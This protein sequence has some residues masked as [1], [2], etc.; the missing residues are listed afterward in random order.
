[1]YQHPYL[2]I[3]YT[4]FLNLNFI[5]I[6]K[7]LR[8]AL[9]CAFYM[10]CFMNV[11]HTQFHDP[12]EGTPISPG[13]ITPRPSNSD[14]SIELTVEHAYALPADP[15]FVVVTYDVT[16]PPNSTM[17]IRLEGGA[18]LFTQNL[19]DWGN[20]HVVIQ[21]GV[22]NPLDALLECEVCAENAPPEEC[23]RVGCVAVIEVD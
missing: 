18:T 20:P 19:S 17:T 12:S 8:T 7:V 16:A 13:S 22:P 15:N 10:I 23:A 9:F 1:M 4:L 2:I 14:S 21:L 5:K 6:M 3:I 11:G